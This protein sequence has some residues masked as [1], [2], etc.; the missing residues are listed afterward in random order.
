MTTETAAKPVDRVV[1]HLSTLY[2]TDGDN[3]V[4]GKPTRLVHTARRGDV[5]S[6]PPDEVRRLENLGAL[7]PKGKK[8]EDAEAEHAAVLDEYRA[9]RGDTDALNRHNDRVLAQR[10]SSGEGGIVDVTVDVEND[11]VKAIADYLRESKPNADD[12]VA[13]AEGD[14]RKAEKLLEAENIASG[15]QPRKTVERDLS[16]IIDEA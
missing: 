8:P 12:T 7:L 14:A 4:T 5:I 9:R 10:P 11:T 2:F 1:R 15:Q 3:P 6:L 16:K 13:L